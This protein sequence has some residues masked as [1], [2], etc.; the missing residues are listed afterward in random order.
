MRHIRLTGMHI[1]D[2]VFEEPIDRRMLPRSVAI[3]E[4][5]SK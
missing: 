2:G 4:A 5:I 3:R 1:G